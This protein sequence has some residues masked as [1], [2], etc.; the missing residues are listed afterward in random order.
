MVKGNITLSF[1][2]NGR[3]YDLPNTLNDIGIDKGK[4]LLRYLGYVNMDTISRQR[5]II[6]LLCDIDMSELDT[7]E[8]E[9]IEVIYPKVDEMINNCGIS[10]FKVLRYKKEYFGLIDIDK[11]TVKQYMEIENILT[12]NSNVLDAG[13]KIMNILYRPIKISIKDKIK[14]RLLPKLDLLKLKIVN[15][16]GKYEIDKD[17]EDVDLT[18]FYT[19]NIS[20]AY[21]FGLYNELMNYKKSLYEIYYPLFSNDSDKH[22]RDNGLAEELKRKNIKEEHIETVGDRWLWYDIINVMCNNNKIEFDY[23]L[24]KNIEELMKHLCYN[25]EKNK[26]ELKKQ[27]NS[28]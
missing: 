19:N 22:N 16:Q 14:S 6:S 21:I 4:Q 13:V 25:I 7:V 15:I 9:L 20:C 24:D 8:D 18:D 10:I 17:K 12:E 1:R 11:L 26:E 5:M 27:N 2:I 23:W 28:R 3:L